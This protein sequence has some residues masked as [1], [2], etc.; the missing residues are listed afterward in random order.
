LLLFTSHS[1]LSATCSS[2]ANAHSR[3]SDTL[4][5]RSVWIDGLVDA[6]ILF[7]RT[8]KHTLRCIS[9]DD[10]SHKLWFEFS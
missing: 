4:N 2:A 8:L 1:E 3:G 9:V 5:E 6:D 7:I 10:I